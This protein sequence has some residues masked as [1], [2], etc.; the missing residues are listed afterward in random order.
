M[1]NQEG[2]QF[3]RAYFDELFGRRNIAAL[4]A[5]LDP[6]YFDHDIGDPDVDHLQSSKQFL[7]TLFREQPTIAVE[8]RDAMAQD[9]VLAAFLEWSVQEDGRKRVLRKGVAVFVLRQ[10]KILKR[11]T[12]I[13]EQE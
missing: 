10:G 9:D 11:Q 8:V 6:E 3:V 2:L 5:Y 1:N 4:D 7:E 12:F 13:Y